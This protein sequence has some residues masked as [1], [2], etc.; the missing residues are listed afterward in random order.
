VRRGLS[1]TGA[2]LI[3]AV[4]CLLAADAWTRLR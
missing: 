4:G 1:V 3:T 2:L